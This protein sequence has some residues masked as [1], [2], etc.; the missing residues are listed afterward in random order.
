VWAGQ[1]TLVVERSDQRGSTCPTVRF[2]EGKYSSL[3]IGPRR[4][5]TRVQDPCGWVDLDP[6]VDGKPQCP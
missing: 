1:T 2:R 3:G 6:G 5:V 4:A